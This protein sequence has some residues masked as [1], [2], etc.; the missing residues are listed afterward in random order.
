MALCTSSL[1]AETPLRMYLS[2]MNGN[3]VIKNG[4]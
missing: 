2:S 4:F 1:L 3:N